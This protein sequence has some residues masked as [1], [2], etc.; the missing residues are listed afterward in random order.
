MN[1]PNSTSLIVDAAERILADLADPQTVN[2]ATGDVWRTPLWQALE[3]SGM[4]LAWMPE[5]LGG[6]GMSMGEVFAILESA[7]RYAAPVALAET[8]LASWLLSQADLPAPTGAMT[9]IPMHPNE[10]ISLDSDGTLHGV[11]RRVRFAAAADHHVVLAQG[12]RGYML[13]MVDARQCKFVPRKGLDDDPL[14][15][16]VLDGVRPSTLG[17]APTSLTPAS[18]LMVGAAVRSLQI[19]GSLQTILARCVDYAGERVAF[20]KPI[21]KFQAIQHALAVLASETAAATAAATSAADALAAGAAGDEGVFLEVA[22]AKIR[23]GEAAEKACAIAHQIHGAI[24]FTQEHV[25]HRFT[26]RALAWRDD[27]GSERFWANE[28]GRRVR[29]WGAD[30]LWPMLA[31]R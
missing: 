7:G 24:G 13:A 4:T 25:L 2:A 29:D 20:E 16:V 21:S 17:G 19:A 1:S 30:G 14:A 9:P 5:S 18:L 28:L 8:L 11:A 10:H 27:F 26:L 12:R 6:A 15:D 3:E 22:S 23:C 31:S